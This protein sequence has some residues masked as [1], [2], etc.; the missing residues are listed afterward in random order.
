MLLPEDVKKR[1]KL[2]PGLSYLELVFKD[3]GVGFEQQF[4]DKVFLIFQRLHSGQLYVGTGIGLA[5]CQNIVINHGGEIYAEAIEY[6]GA[7]FH[8]LLPLTQSKGTVGN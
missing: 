6:E 4:A 1:A 8:V 5:L 3:N 2:N 7:T